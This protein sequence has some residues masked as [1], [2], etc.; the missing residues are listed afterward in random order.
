VKESQRIEKL[1]VLIRFSGAFEL[2]SGNFGI[3]FKN[4]GFHAFWSK[5]IS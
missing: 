1:L 3:G 2:G 4:V 5:K